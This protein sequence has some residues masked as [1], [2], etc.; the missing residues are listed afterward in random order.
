MKAYVRD[1]EDGTVQHQVF[2]DDPGISTP[3]WRL[4]DT[5]A[6]PFVDAEPE[7]SKRRNKKG[8]R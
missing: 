8:K 6:K 5:T 1:L 4:V 2:A 3:Q 7:V